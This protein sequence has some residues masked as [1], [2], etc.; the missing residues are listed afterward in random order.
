MAK[1]IGR[2]TALGVAKETP[3]G[4]SAPPVIGVKW[5]DLSA[6]TKIE[7]T[8]DEE[9]FG[10]IAMADESTIIKRWGEITAKMKLHD[11]AIGYF[12]LSTFGTV[13]STEKIAPNTG[14]YDHEFSIANSNQHPSLTIALKSPNENTLRYPLAMVDSFK[15]EL[16]P[17]N[18]P[19]AEVAMMCKEEVSASDTITYQDEVDFLVKQM[20]FKYA[21]DVSLLDAAS[22]VPLIKSLSFEIKKNLYLE[23]VVGTVT[24]IDILNQ[25]VEITGSMTLVY[26]NNDFRTIQNNEESKAFRFDFTNPTIIGTSATPRLKI[27]MNKV[28]LTNYEVNRSPND[29]VEESFDFEAFYKVSEAEQITA[30]LTNTIASY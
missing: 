13:Q 28:K 3:R 21:D 30:L 15:V 23:Y 19:T 22:P 6:Q 18:Y 2:Q 16:D 12:L 9:A 25:S 8:R 26:D 7:S 27:D 29:I 10:N 1:F 17:E 20:E 14:V 11:K 4:N 5:I 24:P